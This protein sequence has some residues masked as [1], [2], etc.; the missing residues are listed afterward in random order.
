[1]QR[2]ADVLVQLLISQDVSKIF[3]VPGESYLSALDSLYDQGDVQVI[4]CRHEASACHA[5]EAHAKFT[6]KVGVCFVTR[7]PGAMQAAIGVH[8]AQQDST[9]LI[10]FVGQVALADRH[11]EAFQEMD[12]AQIFGSVAKW[13]AEVPSAERMGEY[14]ER[15]FRVARAGRPGPVV[16]A[17]PEEVLDGP[18]PAAGIKTPDA[19]P[20]AL[21]P[22]FVEALRVRLSAAQRPVLVLGGSGWNAL[23][24]AAIAEF[25]QANQLATALSFRRKHLLDNESPVYVGDLGL[26]SNPALIKAVGD[27][28]LILAIGA[29]LGENPTQGYTLFSRAETAQK[30]V[31]I[32]ADAAEIGKV[33]PASLSGVAGPVE[34]AQVLRGLRV[35]APWAERTRRMRASYEAFSS[36][37]SVNGPL[38]LSEVFTHLRSALPADAVVCNGAGNYAAWLHR[39]YRHRGFA[40]QLAPIS[41]SMGYGVPAALAAKLAVPAREVFAIAGDGCF[42]MAGHELATAQQYNAGFVVLVVDNGGFG[43]IRMH[44]ARRFP[45]RVSGTELKNPDFCAYAESFG[46]WA[47]RVERTEDF[48]AALAGARASKQLALLHLVTSLDDIAPGQTLKEIEKA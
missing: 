39:F 24:C 3:C 30:L 37:I 2:A 36:P 48:P 31:H 13:V 25:A 20:P 17:L 6:G 42:L 43:T 29:R 46:A 38:N 7:G 47:R 33:W 11:R 1:M 34:A 22:A 14:V 9:P 16:L 44:Q 19:H 8:T 12:Y 23:A 10:L 4:A 5:A 26:G 41:G 40:T 15:A 21:S 18:C 45:G 28:D 27:A 35:T 32:H